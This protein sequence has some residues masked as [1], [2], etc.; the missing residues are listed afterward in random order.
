MRTLPLALAL[1][2][3]GTA[4]PARADEDDPSEHRLKLILNGNA[5]FTQSSKASYRRTDAATGVSFD[6]LPA[7]TAHGLVH[8]GRTTFSYNGNVTEDLKLDG[9]LASTADVSIEG[10]LTV[11]LLRRGRFTL[12][13]FGEF[14]A[15]PTRT[16][17]NLHRANI[18]TEHGAFNIT[19]YAK[20]HAR[21]YYSW[22]RLALGTGFQVRLGRFIPRLQVGFER[23]Q[24]SIDLHLDDEG[25]E[26]LKTLGY[27]AEQ[28]ENRYE[29]DHNLL[30]LM[31]GLEIE[32]PKRF[33][34]DIQGIAAPIGGKLHLSASLGLTWRP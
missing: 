32:L 19:T 5:H 13:A 11:K 22:Y 26:T 29:I 30:I 6:L 24:A 7:L 21:F 9:E 14:E 15:S 23:L 27:D 8:V 3:F 25:K 20:E 28:V 31:P 34:I 17:F 12:L 2:L 33:S 1:V 16:E 4:I 10:G 18:M